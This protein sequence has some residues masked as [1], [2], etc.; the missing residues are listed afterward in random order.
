MGSR[1][2]LLSLLPLVV[3][4]A[5]GVTALGCES[6]TGSS[7]T[8]AALGG[9]ASDATAGIDGTG[10]GDVG[11]D[12]QANAED[13]GP[14]LPRPD[15]G[16]LPD[17]PGTDTQNDTGVVDAGLVD[18]GVPDVGV[19]DVPVADVPV[20]DVPA[21]D[22]PADDTGSGSIW[23]TLPPGADP[24]CPSAKKWTKG[25]S[26]SKSMEPGMACIACHSN[27]EGPGF[28][29]AGTVYP[30]PTAVDKCNG[31]PTI[32]VELTGAD[33]KVFTT[34]TNSAGNFYFSQNIAIPYKARVIAGALSRK[35]F[36]PQT[37][38][39]CNSC[40]TTQGVNGA[41]GR[42]VEPSP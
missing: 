10:A 40:H 12:A 19:A 5:I 28:F 34:T 4:V 9:N 37:D 27:G 33:G 22:V 26:G 30:S 38:G 11:Q 17:V 6:A 21:P 42:I 39:D 20:A 13:L 8:F 35:M 41:P 15:G 32:T 3:S 36:A 29:A 1:I 25:T 2:K 7:G 14:V 31:S 16:A 24:A 18:V 23:P